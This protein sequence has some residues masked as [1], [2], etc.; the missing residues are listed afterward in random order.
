MT[1]VYTVGQETQMAFGI[2]VI[3]LDHWYTA[4]GVL[5][6][7]AGSERVTLAG[8]ADPDRDRLAGIAET[9]AGISAVTDYR[10]LLRREDVDLVAICAPTDQAPEIAQAALRAGKHVLSVKP[11]ARTLAELDAV[12]AVSAETGRF[13]GSFE[14]MQRVHPKAQ[15]LRRLLAEGAIGQ[16]ITYHQVG[17]GGL[18]SPWRGEPSG[19]DSWWLRA[20]QVPGG[21]WLDHAIYAVDLARYAFG[22]E[23]DLR[24]IS[25]LTDRRVHSSL[26]VEDYGA[27]LMR[28]TPT[29]ATDGVA[30]APVTLFIEDTWVADA[31]KGGGAHRLEILGTAGTLRFDP[32]TNA[33]IV[34]KGSATPVSHPVSASPFFILDALPEV[35]E[36]HLRGE[37][38]PFGAADA[39][40]NLEI[41]LR[42]Y[43]AAR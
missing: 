24:T 16:P 5:D 39:R 20:A 11:P 31:V 38:T 29:G 10:E 9:T 23:V 25:G 30:L 13:Y 12:L 8:V 7:A 27:A 41:C 4:F 19:G 37:A 40:A 2:A 33:W 15:T 6:I 18:P 34:T 32:A 26:A 36:Q 35:T 14:G 3:G 43:A 1:L 28:L 21:A 42:F 17:H 22:G